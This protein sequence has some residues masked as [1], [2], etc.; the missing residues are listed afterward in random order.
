MP[1]ANEDIHLITLKT[2]NI[3][4][5]K[6]LKGKKVGVGTINQ[7]TQITAKLVKEFTEGS[8]NEIE[9]DLENGLTALFA[10]KIDA[11]FFVGSSPVQVLNELTNGQDLELVPITA[12]KMNKAYKPS[13]IKANS[14]KWLTTDVETFAVT[15]VLVTNINGETSE[16]KANID[17]MLKDIYQNI[18]KLKQDG[19]KKWSEV[20]FDFSDVKLDIYPS[21][22][23]IFKK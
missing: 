20:N 12:K 8:W 15:S 16:Q 7:G 3:K 19:H 13:I 10:K 11:L 23:E 5:I 14:Y 22:L 21:S 6:D 9:I 18:E 4:S 1:L 17:G 2:N